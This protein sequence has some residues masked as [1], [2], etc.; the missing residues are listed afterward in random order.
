MKTYAA[1]KPVVAI[2][3]FV[4]MLKVIQSKQQPRKLIILGSDGSGNL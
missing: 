3:K 1:H 4:P 2:K